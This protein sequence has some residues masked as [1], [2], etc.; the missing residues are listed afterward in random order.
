MLASVGILRTSERE[1]IF[2]MAE[3]LGIERSAAAEL[4]T[5]SRK[6]TRP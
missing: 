5:F 6:S 4:P 2:E 3:T 1:F